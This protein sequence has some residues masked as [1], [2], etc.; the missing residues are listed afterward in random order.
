MTNVCVLT[1]N[2]LAYCIVAILTTI[3]WSPM[4]GICWDCAIGIG[5]GS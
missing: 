5:V 4:N 1:N 3:G 2:T